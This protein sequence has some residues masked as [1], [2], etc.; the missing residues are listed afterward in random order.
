MKKL[1][2]LFFVFIAFNLFSQEFNALPAEKVFEY[3]SNGNAYSEPLQ[4]GIFISDSIAINDSLT[5]PFAYYIPSRYDVQSRSPL[6]VYLHG[7]V[8][9]ASFY[10]MDDMRSDNEFIDLAEK[11]NLLLLI[12]FANLQCMWWDLTGAEN[13]LNQIKIMKQKFNVDDNRVFV[14]G[15][16][17][18]GSGS[19]HLAMTRPDVFASFYPLIGMMSVGNLENGSQTYP[20]NLANRFVAAVNNDGDRLYPSAKMR[21][22]SDMAQQAGADLF[23]KE[24]WGLGHEVPYLNDYFSTMMNQMETH[25]RDPFQSKLYWEVSEEEFKKCDW[26]EITEIDTMLEAAEW[27]KSYNVKLTDDRM[28][29]GFIHDEKYTREGTQIIKVVEK[30]AADKAG[31]QAGDFIIEMDGK[32]AANIDTLITWR[33]AKQR[34]DGFTFTVL[35]NDSEIFLEGQFPEITTYDAFSFTRKSGAVKARYYGNIF[36]IETSRVKEIAL[37]FHPE[38]INLEIPVIVNINGKKVFEDMIDFDKKFM[39][40]NFEQNPDR[41]ALWINKLQLEVPREM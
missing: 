3:L 34:G 25:T 9:T 33:D 36:E 10:T 15:I 7:G 6:L 23:Y 16:S 11:Y 5:A 19:F 28:M 12:P 22:L 39:I 14:T 8:G 2:I 4:K 32:V 17:D 31:L 37:Y 41:A 21:L 26:L 35:R 29:F 38:M 18:G 20:A 27:H 30:S 13:I 1:L 40:S 24:F